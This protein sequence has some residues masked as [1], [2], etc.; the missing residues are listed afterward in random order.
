MT[1]TEAK[2]AEAVLAALDAVR[3]EGHFWTPIAELERVAVEPLPGM[4]DFLPRWRGVVAARASGQRKDDWE[5]DPD[6]WLSEATR[7]LE[8]P[9][10]LASLARRTRRAHDLLAWCQS[11]RETGDWDRA[12]R[13]LGEAAKLARSS[14]VRADLLDGAA[15]AAHQ[16]GRDDVAERLERAWRASP[17]LLRLCRWLDTAPGPVVLKTRARKALSLCPKRAHRQRVFLYVLTGHP[18]EAVRLVAAAPG[19][20]WSQE[21]H[22][23]HLGFWL[24]AAL[25]APEGAVL[26]VGPPNLA[27]AAESELA[28]IT[29]WPTDLEAQNS[30]SV[31]PRLPLPDLTRIVTLADPRPPTGSAARAA[32]LM[33]LRTAA[34]RRAAGVTK[35]K[36][37]RYYEHVARL[38][39]TCVAVDRG[40]DTTAWVSGIRTRYRRFS[41]M[42]TEFERM[43]DR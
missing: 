10:G 25:I 18:Q 30:T 38:V 40:P 9:E 17:T 36:R 19:L 34:E 7:R 21:E 27:S 43:L 4:A 28:G 23:G 15:I 37:R 39:G 11:V 42:Q 12:L 26:A 29:E 3:A 24:L 33:A 2:R 31:V 22:P 20:G 13:A 32:L 5:T 35:E 1:S 6:R 16:L 41:A 8:G 14:A